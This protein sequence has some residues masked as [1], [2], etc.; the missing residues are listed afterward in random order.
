MARKLAHRKGRPDLQGSLQLDSHLMATA[1][2]IFIEHGYEGASM[3]QI[4][5]AAGAGKQSLYRRYANKEALFKAVF[6]DHLARKQIERWDGEMAAF[7][8]HE[9]AAADKPLDDLRDIARTA[10]NNLFEEETVD[11]FRLFVGEQRRFPDLRD[12]MK[13]ITETFEDEITGRLRIAEQQGLFRKDVGQH[14]ARNLL[15]LVIEGPL[16]QA[17]LGLPSVDTPAK[18]D[19]YFE[20]AWTTFIDSMGRR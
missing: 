16:F 14:A 20:A 1:A 19:A 12:E 9:T 11:L 18:R 15:A 4:A 7:E 10:F 17:L 13:Q 8:A 3:D 6:T 5:A 2:K